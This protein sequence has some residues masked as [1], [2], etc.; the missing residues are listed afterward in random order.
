MTMTWME[1]VFT[2]GLM[3]AVILDNIKMIENMGTA[4]TS[5]KMGA[6]I[7]DNGC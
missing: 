3:D 2:H 1:W 6:F 5:G 4:F 7:W